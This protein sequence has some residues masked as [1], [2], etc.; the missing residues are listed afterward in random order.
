MPFMPPLAGVWRSIIRSPGSI[1]IRNFAGRNYFR[2]E[3]LLTRRARELTAAPHRMMNSLFSFP[4][5]PNARHCAIV[6]G[7]ASCGEYFRDGA[8]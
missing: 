8:Q 3:E 7:P 2:V 6:A 4:E 1:T 5:F